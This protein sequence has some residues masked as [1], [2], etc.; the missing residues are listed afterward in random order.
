LGDSL[1]SSPF[2]GSRNV[3]GGSVVGLMKD[4]SCAH[5]RADRTCIFHI[6]KLLQVSFS[7]TEKPKDGAAEIVEEDARWNA[8]EVLHVE[9]NGSE[10]HAKMSE[11]VAPWGLGYVDLF[12]NIHMVRI[13]YMSIQTYEIVGFQH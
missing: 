9:L 4:V 3:E 8:M 6:E 1:F 12:S 11:R 5:L 2:I 7:I 10:Y 13:I